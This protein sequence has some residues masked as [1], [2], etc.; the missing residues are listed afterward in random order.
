MILKQINDSG[1]QRRASI[2]P[3]VL[4]FLIS[5]IVHAG[6]VVLNFTDAVTEI[7]QLTTQKLEV[8][9]VTEKNKTVQQQQRTA[10]VKTGK[11]I[12]QETLNSLEKKQIKKDNLNA[13]IDKD[14]VQSREEVSES[15][16]NEIKIVNTE[17][18]ETSKST[19]TDEQLSVLIPQYYLGKIHIEFARHFKY[20][21]RA[22]RKQLQGKVILSFR[23]NTNGVISTISVEK[24]SGY[25]ILDRA[26]VTSL[27]RV[28]P[29]DE[30]PDKDLN[31]TLPV[32]Y[33][34]KES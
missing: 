2:G 18:I 1:L 9:L 19:R 7:G 13:V 29:L 14:A 6:I 21:R 11:A 23:L 27:K 3:L 12:Q 4:F 33:K 25:G 34:L 26:A 8:V 31:F 20:P 22:Q 32:I 16:A 15:V 10:P 17:L 28:K 5:F 24:S 30:Y